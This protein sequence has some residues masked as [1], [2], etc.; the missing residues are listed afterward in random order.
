MNNQS[1]D[2]WLSLKFLFRL[3]V[4]LLMSYCRSR[5]FLGSHGIVKDGSVDSSE[6]VLRFSLSER[7]QGRDHR[8]FQPLHAPKPSFHNAGSNRSLGMHFSVHK[9]AEMCFSRTETHG[10]HFPMHCLRL[11][12]CLLFTGDFRWGFGNRK[13]HPRYAYTCQTSYFLF[14]NSF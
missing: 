6:S 4:D 2:P 13:L 8:T 14:I 9:F 5:A 1:L 3:G 10:Q 11:W 12:R 7:I